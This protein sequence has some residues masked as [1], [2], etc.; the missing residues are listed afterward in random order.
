MV[1]MIYKYEYERSFLAHCYMTIKTFLLKETQATKKQVAKM[2]VP[3]NGN[4]KLEHV[5]ARVNKNVKL[6][7]LWDSSNVMAVKRLKMTD[8]GRTHVA[9]VSNLALKLLRNLKRA[10]VVPDSVCDHKLDYEDSE[11]IVFLAS[12][13]HDIGNAVSREDHERMSIA[14]APLMIEDILKDIY[15]ERQ[16]TIVTTEI[17]HAML[18]H[19]TNTTLHTTEGGVVMIADGLDME[20]GRARIPFDLGKVDIHSVSAL[21]IEDVKVLYTEQIPIQIEI[22]MNNSAGIFQIDYL[23][24]KKIESSTIS[25]YVSVTARVKDGREKK[26]IKEYNLNNHKD[27]EGGRE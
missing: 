9:I 10:G 19:D 20:Q 6:N 26:I 1:A 22:L 15:P 24:K 12:V 2:N 14:L 11:V 16:R 3:T 25:K 13:F 8:H 17:L 4:K 21:S 23:L 18:C 27:M 7:T 5:L